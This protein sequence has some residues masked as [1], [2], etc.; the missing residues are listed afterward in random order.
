MTAM[1][2][3]IPLPFL[4]PQLLEIASAIAAIAEKKKYVDM[5]ITPSL[6]IICYVMH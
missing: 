4:T 2:I 6:S 3:H 1:S 5:T